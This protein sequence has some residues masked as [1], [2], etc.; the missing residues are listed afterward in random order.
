M[1]FKRISLLTGALLM[2]LTALAQMAMTD[3][4]VLDYITQGLSEGKSARAIA[5]ELS[6]QGVSQDQ[7]QRVYALFKSQNAGTETTGSLIEETRSHSSMS[8]G[9]V[10]DQIRDIRS[11]YSDDNHVYGYSIFRDRAMSFSPSENMATPRD[12]RLGPGDEVIVDIFGVNQATIRQHITPEGNINVDVLGPLYISGMTIDEADSYLKKRLSKIYGGLN[13]RSTDIKLTLGQ[14]RS[15]QVNVLGSV[16]QPGTYRVSSFSTVMH[17]LYR[18]GGVVNPGTLRSI[19]I[20]RAG[21]TIGEIDLYKFLIDGDLSSDIRLE[22]GDV[23]LVQPYKARVEI[24]GEVRRSMTFEVKDG[25]TLSDLIRYAGGFTTTALQDN[26]TVTRRDGVSFHVYS[27]SLSDFD[28]FTLKDGDQIEV[29]HLTSLVQNRLEINGS[30]FNPGVYELSS[31]VRTVN[32]LV[33]KAGGLLPE[34]FTNRAVIQRENDDKTVEVLAIDLEKV[35]AGTAPDVELRNKDILTISSKYDLS[36]LGTMTIRGEVVNPGSYTFA[37]NT[38]IEDLIII[39]GGLKN[40]AATARVD[41]TRRV[42]NNDGTEV[43]KTIAELITVS[44]DDEFKVGGESFILE[45]YDEVTIHRS[46]DFNVNKHFTVNG[47]V[48]FEG[49]YTMTDRQERLSD[50]VRKA[51]GTTDFAYLRGARLIRRMNEFEVKQQR[52]ARQSLHHISEGSL[53]DDLYETSYTIAIQLDKALANPGSDYDV[54]LREDDYLDIPVLSNTVNVIGAVMLPNA[55]AYNA[56]KRAGHYVKLCGG[57]AH[58]AFKRKA[59]IVYM[60]GEAHRMHSNSHV[61]PGSEIIIPSKGPAKDGVFANVVSTARDFTYTSAL[62]TSVILN[63]LK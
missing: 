54:I 39:A 53:G 9:E 11:E 37:S 57:Y 48:N 41:V 2:S 55:Q 5:V 28:S 6:A 12:Y 31:E 25:E 26:V 30:V 13:G 44:I 20:N 49:T 32:Q 10:S 36:Q 15:I 7:A 29:G 17:V 38:S 60:N 51:G 56:N 34:A 19:R 42:R 50:L 16:V 43:Q 27:L 24:Q 1:N 18:V 21:Q 62:V 59:Y 33:E 23:I 14:I 52:E 4:Q 61:E 45:P 8:L 63:L 3:Q 46:P 40:G 58:R 22:E 47:E 35:L